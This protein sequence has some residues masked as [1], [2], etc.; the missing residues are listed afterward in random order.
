MTKYIYSFIDRFKV[1][2]AFAALV[3]CGALVAGGAVSFY[4]QILLNN[5]NSSANDRVN[6]VVNKYE[7]YLGTQEKKYE[8]QLQ[9]KQKELDTSRA[10]VTRL[11]D[12]IEKRLPLIVA[13][14]DQN[15]DQLGQLAVAVDSVATK[16]KQ[17]ASTASKAAS[18]A[19]QAVRKS[20]EPI[21]TLRMVP[22]KPVKLRCRGKDVFGDPCP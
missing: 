6:S 17:A 22:S 20:R 16:T 18:Q 19:G 4:F 5:A 21:S 13:Q 15:T 8:K 11:T 7:G 14:Q 1:G 3:L 9:V 2:L 10:Q 12:T